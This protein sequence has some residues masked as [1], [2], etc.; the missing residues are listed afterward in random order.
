MLLKG[1]VILLEDTSFQLLSNLSENKVCL[2]VSMHACIIPIFLFFSLR[3]VM[4][5]LC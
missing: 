1:A 5:G 4:Y 3:Q 2:Y